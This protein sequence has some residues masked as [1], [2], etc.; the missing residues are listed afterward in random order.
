MNPAITAIAS[1]AAKST[2]SHSILSR[3]YFIH[4]LCSERNKILS[5]HL[6]ISPFLQMSL[7]WG[8]AVSDMRLY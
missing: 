4:R 3:R 8:K 7:L 5:F 1:A 2:V 6:M